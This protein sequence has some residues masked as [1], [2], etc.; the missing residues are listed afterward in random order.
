MFVSAGRAE[1][2]FIENSLIPFFSWSNDV[3]SVLTGVTVMLAVS[4][5]TDESVLVWLGLFPS[6]FVPQPARPAHIQA[7][8]SNAVIRFFIV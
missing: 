7:L 3:M 6:V 4:E 2:I 8:S 1:Y 5:V